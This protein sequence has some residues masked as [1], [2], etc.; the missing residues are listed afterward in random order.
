MNNP[1]DSSLPTENCFKRINELIHYTGN[2]M[3]LYT[4]AQ[5][6]QKAQ[7]AVLASGMY[8]NLQI[9]EENSVNEYGLV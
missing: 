5:V 9:M 7:H 1:I 4:A 3:T 8:I 2:D 6:I